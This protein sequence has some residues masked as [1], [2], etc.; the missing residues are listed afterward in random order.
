MD[1]G[2]ATHGSLEPLHAAYEQKQWPD[3]ADTEPPFSVNSDIHRG[4]T[5]APCHLRLGQSTSV[6]LSL[7]TAPPH[8]HEDDDNTASVSVKGVDEWDE[9]ELLKPPSQPGSGSLVTH[10][11]VTL[12]DQQDRAYLAPAGQYEDVI[13]YHDFLNDLRAMR[14]ERE[15]ELEAIRR[16]SSEIQHDLLRARE[17]IQSCLD[18]VNGVLADLPVSITGD[19]AREIPSTLATS[20]SVTSQLLPAC[21]QDDDS[22]KSDILDGSMRTAQELAEEE[23]R[24]SEDA[25]EDEVEAVVG[26]KPQATVESPILDEEALDVLWRNGFLEHLTATDPSLLGDRDYPIGAFD[27]GTMDD[28]RLETEEQCEEALKRY[29]EEDEEEQYGEEDTSDNLV[30]GVVDPLPETVIHSSIL[31]TQELTAFVT[32]DVPGNFTAADPSG[33]DYTSENDALRGVSWDEGRMRTEEQCEEAWAC[34]GDEGNEEVEMEIHEAPLPLPDQPEGEDDDGHVDMDVDDEDYRQCFP[35]KI[36]LSNQSTADVPTAETSL[37]SSTAQLSM[38]SCTGL[39][40]QSMTAVETSQQATAC[41]SDSSIGEQANEKCMDNGIATHGS[42]EPLHAAYEQKQWPD[43]TDT[44]PPFSDL[45]V[46]CSS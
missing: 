31:N 28:E 5:K 2:I 6:G 17:E 43:L 18:E 21:I 22:W 12:V 40:S 41:D 10:S 36:S 9:F 42:L 44:K 30:E 23:Q 8:T 15:L 16:E 32:S 25:S 24:T 46:S 27:G 4:Y 19:S 14:E 7:A 38:S 26:L 37:T 1:N 39:D 3:L 20:E 45:P 11:E 33:R 34:R 29:D 35:V 13:G